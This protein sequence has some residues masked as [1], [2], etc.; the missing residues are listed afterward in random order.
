MVF[1]HFVVFHALEGREENLTSA[2]TE[3]AETARTLDC[4]LDFTFG[5]NRNPSGLAH[6][7]THG[8]YMRMTSE[9]DFKSEYWPHPAHRRLLGRLDELCADRF[10]IYYDLPG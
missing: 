4:V 5:E 3:F 9:E 7:Y 1:E 10:G 6:G 8:C 2:L